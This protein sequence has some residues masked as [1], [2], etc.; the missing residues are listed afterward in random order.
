MVAVY[1]A[2]LGKQ[3]I[4]DVASLCYQKAHYAASQIA[5]ISGYSL[6]VKGIFFH[7]FAVKCPK[8]VSEINAALLKRKIIGGFDISHRIPDTMLLCVTEMNSREEIDALVS[9][10]REIGGGK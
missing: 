9:A 5:K 8:P 4:R 3:G 1:V 2:T 10:L 7:E 6:P